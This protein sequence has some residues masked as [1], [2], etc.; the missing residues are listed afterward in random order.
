MQYSLT[1]ASVII[2][3]QQFKKKV[4]IYLFGNILLIGVHIAII[5]MIKELTKDLRR[6]KCVKK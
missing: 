4:Y 3:D 6:I 5:T 2:F 1:I